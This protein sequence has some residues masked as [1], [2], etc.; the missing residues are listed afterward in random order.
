MEMRS[1]QHKVV[2][3]KWVSQCN[4]MQTVINGP[5]NLAPQHSSVHKGAPSVTRQSNLLAQHSSVRTMAPSVTG[6]LN[7][8]PHTR[9]IQSVASSIIRPSKLALKSKRFTSDTDAALTTEWQDDN[10]EHEISA[11][12]D[13]TIHALMNDGLLQH[14]LMQMGQQNLMQTGEQNLMQTGV[15]QQFYPRVEEI[16]NHVDLAVEKKSER[17][18]KQLKLTLTEEETLTI[19]NCTEN[20]HKLEIHATTQKQSLD[21]LKSRDPLKKTAYVICGRGRAEDVKV[22]QSLRCWKVLVLDVEPSMCLATMQSMCVPVLSITLGMDYITAQDIKEGMTLYIPQI[23]CTL[24]P[25]PL[26]ELSQHAKPPCAMRT[27][28]RGFLE[29]DQNSNETGHQLS[30]LYETDVIDMDCLVEDSSAP[31]DVLVDTP[32]PSN[33]ST[34]VLVDIPLPSHPLPS[35]PLPTPLSTNVLT[36]IPPPTC[37]PTTVLTNVPLKTDIPLPTCLPTN[38]VTDVSLPTDIPLPIDVSAIFV[39]PNKFSRQKDVL[40]ENFLG[41][42]VANNTAI[43]NFTNSSK[44]R[45]SSTSTSHLTVSTEE[46]DMEN[47]SS[48]DEKTKP[49]V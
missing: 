40:D 38:V 10:S 19:R 1:L 49:E 20:S 29:G 47:V 6:Q 12:E 31:T 16:F 7:L 3:R 30:M 42:Y 22:I 36:D 4:E 21:D 37:L 41:T 13:N 28:I 25:D 35:H 26:I 8:V 9:S 2:L 48:A 44:D 17:V 45:V 24:R 33:V 11:T 18:S 27:C 15:Q 43:V 46:S 23:H 14:N 39:E 34:K 5:P 32:V